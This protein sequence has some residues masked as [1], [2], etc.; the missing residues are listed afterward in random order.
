MDWKLYRKT[1]TIEARPYVPG[2]DL[3]GVAVNQKDDL[4]EGGMICRNPEDPKDSWYCAADYFNVYE[5]V[6]RG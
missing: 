1:A 4:A 2:E 5:E 6:P 3:K